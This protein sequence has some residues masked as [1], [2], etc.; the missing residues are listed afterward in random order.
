MAFRDLFYL[1][2]TLVTKGIPGE[3]KQQANRLEY[4]VPDPS[5][6]NL[7]Q[8]TQLLDA[9]QVR[10][11]A[12]GGI[13]FYS[14]DQP[15]KGLFRLTR[16]GLA[17]SR[18]S[19]TEWW[20]I[21]SPEEALDTLTWLQQE[22]HRQA[23]NSKLRKEPAYWQQEFAGKKAITYSADLH[24]GAW[25]YARLVNVARWSYDCQYLSWE[26]A[27]PFIAKGNKLA[28]REYDS[29]EAFAN[30]FMAG[31]VMWQPNSPTY[32]DIAEVVQTLL[33]A[34]D[35]VWRQYPWQSAQGM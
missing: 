23:F 17:R 7:Q 28:G 16:I 13:L 24:V 8:P 6:F 30:G 31:R 11:L 21:S 10:A 12:T 20:G 14:G 5:D 27:W 22:G 4:G 3:E 18:A 35:S 34:P 33:T 19:L 29:W 2:A 25:D 9:A 1:A 26:Q 32:D 15:I